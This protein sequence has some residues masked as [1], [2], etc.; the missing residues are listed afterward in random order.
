MIAQPQAKRKRTQPSSTSTSS[1]AN[2]SKRHKETDDEE[3]QYAQRVVSAQAASR[4][5]PLSK[6]SKQYV[7][8]ALDGAIVYVLNE[9]G[10]SSYDDVQD[11]LNILRQRIVGSLSAITVPSV[12]QPDYRHMEEQCNSMEVS[13]AEAS[14]HVELLEKEIDNQLRFIEEKEAMIEELKSTS[15]APNVSRIHP[16]LQSN[17]PE[18]LELPAVKPSNSK[19]QKVSAASSSS[20]H[21]K[22]LVDVLKKWQSQ[23]TVKDMTTFMESLT[24]VASTL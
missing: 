12:R 15:Q 8:D 22:K 20:T 18:K 13:V 17:S 14:N 5:K 21:H 6:T 23:D 24:N 11:T 16:I 3:E 1:K 9:T 10:S 19:T 4:W 7:L 2:K